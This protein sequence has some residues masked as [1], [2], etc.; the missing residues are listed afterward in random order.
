[1][2]N[3][4]LMSPVSRRYLIIVEPKKMQKYEGVS[5]EGEYVRFRN[6]Y[7]EVSEEVFEI[8]K[9]RP[10]FGVDYVEVQARQVL[11]E[12]VQPTVKAFGSEI[13][14]EEGKGMRT[15][16]DSLKT[17]VDLITKAVMKLVEHVAP[18]SKEIE[19]PKTKGKPGPKKSVESEEET[20]EK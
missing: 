1:M 11:P 13:E 7:A 9:Q 17:Q 20:E 16:I 5:S 8:L 19:K 2:A 10:E 15:E 12:L 18:E 14:R 4:L 3:I 6:G